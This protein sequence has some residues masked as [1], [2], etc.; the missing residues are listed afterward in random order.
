MYLLKVK[1]ISRDCISDYIA[2]TK[3]QAIMYLNAIESLNTFDDFSLL[4]LRKLRKKDNFDRIKC[5]FPD[6]SISHIRVE[7]GEARFFPL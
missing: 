7:N 1:N 6:M 4:E 3:R 5:I 2:G